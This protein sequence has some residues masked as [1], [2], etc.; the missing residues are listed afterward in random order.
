M[1]SIVVFAV[2][3]LTFGNSFAQKKVHATGEKINSSP[4]FNNKAESMKNG[5]WGTFKDLQGEPI[6]DVQ[7]MVYHVDTIISSGFSDGAGRFTT[8]ACN[9]G[10]YNLKIVYPNSN[11]YAMVSG[12]EIK[13]GKV[14]IDLKANPPTADTSISF[15][16]LLPKKPGDKKNPGRR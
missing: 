9:P 16:D 14:R 4:Y 1:K 10:K 3:L 12:A 15:T 6:A 5:V 11:K 7:V 2:C 13:K 8:S